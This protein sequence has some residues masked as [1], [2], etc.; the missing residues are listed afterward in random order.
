MSAV[1]GL[2]L[3]RYQGARARCSSTSPGS[4]PDGGVP[5]HG[6]GL[7]GELE[8]DGAADRVR[9]AVAGLPGAEFLLGVFYRDLDGPSRGVSFD[10]LGGAGVRVGGDQGQVVA[11]RGPVADEDPWTGRVLKTEYHRQV[12]AAGRT[13][14]DLP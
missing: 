9:G 12:T 5:G 10:D 13:V 7:A 4:W 1:D 3:L 8:R 11:G 2:A 14:S 6:Q